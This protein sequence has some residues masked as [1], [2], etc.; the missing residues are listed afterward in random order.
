MNIR[1]SE[2][3]LLIGAV[4]ALIALA[5]SFGLNLSPAQVGTVLAAVTAVSAVLVRQRVSPVGADRG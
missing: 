4:Q 2:P 5:V 3:A 1:K